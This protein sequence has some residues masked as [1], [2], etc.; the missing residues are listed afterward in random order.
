MGLFV[1]NLSPLPTSPARGEVPFSAF[2]WIGNFEPA[3]TSPRAGEAGRG[4]V[5]QI[6]VAVPPNSA[7]TAHD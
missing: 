7:E 1:L 5:A 3:H 4:A 6:N 2:D